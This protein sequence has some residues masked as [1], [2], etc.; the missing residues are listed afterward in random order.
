[1]RNLLLILIGSI[2]SMF[3]Y[4]QI[5]QAQVIANANSY[6]NLSW[7]A[8]STNI[9]SSV[10]CGGTTVNTPSWVSSGSNSSMPYCW[11]GNSSISSFT[12]NIALG[13]SAGD[14]NTTGNSG[15]I[16]YTISLKVEKR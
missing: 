14:N 7:T 9:W 3:G 13:R 10:S 4:S 2:F 15:V 8:S 5:T 1:M 12:S 11:G 6:L 16:A